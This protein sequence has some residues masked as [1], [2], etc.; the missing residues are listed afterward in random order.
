MK[1]KKKKRQF[2]ISYFDEIVRSLA[3]RNSNGLSLKLVKL[4]I[5]LA[6]FS[7]KWGT[8]GNQKV[9]NTV[10]VQDF[11]KREENSLSSVVVVTY[12]IL[13]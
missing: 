1:K 10:T 6:F 4:C 12:L 9:G 11:A 5:R 2:K 7:K 13:V 8:F 3:S